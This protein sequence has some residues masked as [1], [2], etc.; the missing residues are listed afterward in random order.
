MGGGGGVH[1]HDSTIQI[2]FANNEAL[3]SEAMLSGCKFQ[4]RHALSQRL[5]RMGFFSAQ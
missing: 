4:F 3:Y 5:L 1:E 2:S